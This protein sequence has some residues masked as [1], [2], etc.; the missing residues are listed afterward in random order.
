MDTLRLFR[1]WPTIRFHYGTMEAGKSLQLLVAA[2]ELGQK[3]V[4]YSVYT[5]HP[6]PVAP[7][8]HAVV[9][10]RSGIREHV[11]TF[12]AAGQKLE[13]SGTHVLIDEAQFL[14]NDQVEDLRCF[15]EAH[16]S[17][18]VDCYGLKTDFQGNFFEGSLHLMRSADELVEVPS[19]CKLCTRPATHNMRVDEKGNAVVAGE[20]VALKHTTSYIAVCYCCWRKALVT[21]GSHTP[22]PAHIA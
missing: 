3:Q 4:E 20:Q 17:H 12:I 16:V 9:A 2:Y 7:Q 11:S 22:L 5:V 15:V 19:L 21:A 6:G 10:S 8:E 14:T 1:P 13:L 18:R